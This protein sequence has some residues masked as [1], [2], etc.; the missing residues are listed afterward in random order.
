MDR[1]LDGFFDELMREQVRRIRFILEHYDVTPE[2]ILDII[3]EG[4]E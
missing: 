2:M 4:L 3:K 1:K